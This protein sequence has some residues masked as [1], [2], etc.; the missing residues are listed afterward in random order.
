MKLPIRLSLLSLLLCSVCALHSEE[1]MLLHLKS[2]DIVRFELETKPV[3]TFN[4]NLLSVGNS[5]Y[6]IDNVSKYTFSTTNS[7]IEDIVADTPLIHFD[8]RALITVKSGDN[9]NNI[10]LY[11]IDGKSRPIVF[12][13]TPDGYMTAD[14]SELPLGYYLLRVG[15]KTI[16]I[17]KR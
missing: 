15:E 8:G 11:S 5:H 17:Q 14:I 13:M 6:S 1:M 2:G 12:S 4:G 9:P 16:K 7:G 3:I 10:S